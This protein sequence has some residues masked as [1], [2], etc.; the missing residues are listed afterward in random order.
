LY[1]YDRHR[2]T[3]SMGLDCLGVGLVGQI[4]GAVFTGFTL[5]NNQNPQNP[6]RMIGFILLVMG[7]GVLLG[8]CGVFARYHRLGR[9]CGLLG[10]LSIF[11]VLILLVL[12]RMQQNLPLIPGYQRRHRGFDVVFAEPYRRDVWRM[13]VR[14]ILDQSVASAVREPI[15]LQLPRGANIGTAMKTLASVIPELDSTPSPAER[16]TINGERADRRAELSHGDELAV[17]ATIPQGAHG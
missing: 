5:G 16:F 17:S 3:R 8:G 12:S 15:M 9:W 14:V 11:G 6:L 2:L 10:F 4:I 7:T 13:D 1:V